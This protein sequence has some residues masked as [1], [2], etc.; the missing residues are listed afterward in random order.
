MKEKKSSAFFKKDGTRSVLASLLSIL[1]GMVLA[2]MA[3]GAVA[4]LRRHH[5]ATAI[6]ALNLLLG[7][8][9]F[10]WI[11]ALVWALTAVRRDEDGPSEHASILAR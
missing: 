7:W 6:A 2:Y 8:T 3:P 10:G 11:G 9:G 4:M 5:N 1:I